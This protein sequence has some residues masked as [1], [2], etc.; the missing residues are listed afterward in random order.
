MVT[1][2]T[3]MAWFSVHP[4]TRSVSLVALGAVAVKVKQDYVDYQKALAAN[5]DTPYSILTMIQKCGWGT[6]TAAVV[7]VAPIVW[8][9]V[10]KVLG[11]G[12]LP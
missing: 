3:L 1:E 8:A 6:V 11:G 10:L 9:E 5:P 7:S 12:V 2:S 4:F